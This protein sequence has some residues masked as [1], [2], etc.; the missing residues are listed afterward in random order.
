[1]NKAPAIHLVIP[2]LADFN[3]GLAQSNG[4]IYVVE[5]AKTSVPEFPSKFKHADNVQ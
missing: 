4:S 3:F 5:I 2:I 1:M